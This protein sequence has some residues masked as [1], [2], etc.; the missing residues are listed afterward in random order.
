M[1][2]PA[3]KNIQAQQNPNHLR[4]HFWIESRTRNGLSLTNYQ[5]RRFTS[6]CI[7]VKTLSQWSS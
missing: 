6:I 3:G 7:K 4:S 2:Y 1:K 5:S